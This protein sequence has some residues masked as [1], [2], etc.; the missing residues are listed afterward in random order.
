MGESTNDVYCTHIHA[1]A[2]FGRGS[3]YPVAAHLTASCKIACNPQLTG[4]RPCRFCLCSV[5]WRRWC[6]EL[7][8]RLARIQGDAH[9]DS[10][11]GRCRKDDDFVS[12]AGGRS[13]DNDT[14]HRLQRGTSDIQKSEIPSLGSGRPDQHSA[15]L[16]MLL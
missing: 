1:H 5:S 16:A 3:V 11:A 8:P 10:R 7:F 6:A 15:V 12:L 4:S 9:S 14:D 13:G 2:T